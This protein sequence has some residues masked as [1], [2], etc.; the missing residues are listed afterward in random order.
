VFLIDASNACTQTDF[1]RSVD[2][3]RSIV[4]KLDI[5]SKKT[6]VGLSTITDSGQSPV[7]MADY[8]DKQYLL[9]A[10]DTK[11]RFDN[12][13][14]DFAASLSRVRTRQFVQES[15]ARD[16]I[17]DVLVV[18]ASETLN[19]LSD[20]VKNEVRQLREK[21]VFIIVIVY[22]DTVSR[23]AM[24]DRL[25]S[26]VSDPIE[27]NRFSL[28]SSS[29]LTAVQTDVLKRICGEIPGIDP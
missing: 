26:I 6:R 21:G 7:S 13:L 17:P 19:M 11:A 1:Q 29:D 20:G 12:V 22:G 4:S 25:V 27:H 28:T 23:D 2:F 8:S 5:G 9:N 10:I 3:V 16:K 24:D 15:G 18:I 14:G